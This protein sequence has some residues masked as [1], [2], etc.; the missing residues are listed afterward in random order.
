MRTRKLSGTDGVRI[1]VAILETGDEVMGSLEALAEAE[2]LSAASLTAIGAFE[3][4]ELYF[5]EWENKEYL[6]IPVEEQTEVASLNGD[7][8]EGPDG[9]PLLHIHAV[10]GRADG[11]AIAG[12]LARA[13]VRPTLEVV[14]TETPAH[15][16]RRQDEETGLPLIALGDS[17]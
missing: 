3:R 7:I 6:S 2:G 13:E 11:S 17:G 16:R 14:V 5:F 9:K 12:H 8:A 15:L 10:L 1:L 4:A